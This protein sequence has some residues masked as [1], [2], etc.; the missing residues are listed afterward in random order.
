MGCVTHLI[1]LLYHYFSSCQFGIPSGLTKGD[2]GYGITAVILD[3]SV[4]QRSDFVFVVLHGV[5]LAKI[6]SS[7]GI[8]SQIIYILFAIPRKSCAAFGN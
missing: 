6:E 7:A 1:V 3:S 8:I 2:Y 4:T 5:G